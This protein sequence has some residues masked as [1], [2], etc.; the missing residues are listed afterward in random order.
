M[1]MT[2][3]VGQVLNLDYPDFGPKVVLIK[4][5]VVDLPLCNSKLFLKL[6]VAL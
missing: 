5:K 1:N 4:K 2:K 3:L 6:I